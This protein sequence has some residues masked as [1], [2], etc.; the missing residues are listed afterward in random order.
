MVVAFA[1]EDAWDA[2]KTQDTDHRPATGEDQIEQSV[3]INESTAG[4]ALTIE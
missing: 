2:V 4:L 1:F 3:I